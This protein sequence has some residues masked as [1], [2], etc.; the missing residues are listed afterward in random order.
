[1]ERLLRNTFEDFSVDLKFSL[2]TREK[3]SGFLVVCKQ[4]HNSEADQTVRM[5][6]CTTKEFGRNFLIIKLYVAGNTVY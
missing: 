1:M 6:L 2:L 5:M 3:T 4:K